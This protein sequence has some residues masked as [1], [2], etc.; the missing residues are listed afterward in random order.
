M[1]IDVEC[2]RDILFTV[3]NNATFKKPFR[4]EKCGTK[5]PVLSKY[6]MDK[7]EYHFRYLKMNGMLYVPNPS[8]HVYDQY[9]LTPEGH[10]F[11]ANV[12]DNN[13]WDKVKDIAS[14]INFSGFN[15]LFEIAKGLARIAVNQQLE[16]LK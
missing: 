1:Q 9:D 11:L 10:E 5:Y 7:I 15:S 6:D 4:T 12:R 2:I 16:S 13:H 3:E 14:T 8:H